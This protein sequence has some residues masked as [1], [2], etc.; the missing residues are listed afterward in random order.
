MH[1]CMY[2]G[3]GQDG[4][5]D[6]TVNVFEQSEDFECVPLALGVGLRVVQ[7][8]LDE[9]NQGLKDTFSQVC[10]AREP[11]ARRVCG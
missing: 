1:V 8:R 4:N 2:G 5:W 3:A 9:R 6:S 7:D 11:P 10:F